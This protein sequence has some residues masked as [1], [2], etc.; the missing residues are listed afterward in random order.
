M[1]RPYF[2]FHRELLG[3]LARLAYETVREMMVA[4]SDE[5]IARPGMVT[6]IQTFGSSLK[7]NPHI[8]A[9]VTRGVFLDDGSWHPVPYVDSYKAEL[10]FRHKVLGLLRDRDLITQERIDLL[11]SWRNSGFGVHN[12]TTV[13]P[14]DSEGLHKLACYFMRPPVN[15]SRLRYHRD[16][17]LLLYEPKAPQEVDDEALVDPFE[18][19]ARVLIHIPEPNKHLVHF[20]GVYANRLRAMYRTDDAPSPGLAGDEPPPR[21]TLSKRWAELIYRIYEVDPLDCPHCVTDCI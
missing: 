2:L 21:R 16:S 8:H 1:L 19:L 14:T 11:L 12:R 18:F 9:I 3:E 7:W 6:V 20:Y 13:Y 5:P 17:G 10:I 15:L 4:A